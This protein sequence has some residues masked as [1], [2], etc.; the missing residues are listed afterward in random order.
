M[1]RK[2]EKLSE[3]EVL[4]EYPISGL[5]DGWYFSQKE[6]SP[7]VYEI[8][9][10]DLWGRKVSRSGTDEQQTLKRCVRDAKDIDR[11]S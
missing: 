8:L 1:K 7:G 10:T 2:L 11:K 5:A 4:K 9:G 3:S 6:V